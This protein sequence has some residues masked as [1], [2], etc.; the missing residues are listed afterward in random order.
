MLTSKG[1]AFLYSIWHSPTVRSRLV[2]ILCVVRHILR[3]V[4]E[5]RTD[6]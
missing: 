3:K 5:S 6:T 4:T 2:R 1:I